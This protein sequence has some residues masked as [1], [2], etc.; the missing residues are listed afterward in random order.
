MPHLQ[1]IHNRFESQGLVVVAV[2]VDEE[3]EPARAFRAE[4]GFDFP[5]IFDA[6]RT[7]KSAM[8]GERGA[9]DLHH[10]PAGEPHT[11]QGPATGI[12]STLIDN[13][14]VWESDKIIELLTEV[15]GN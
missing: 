11:R 9:G 3:L 4:Y 2:A 1:K 13:P 15:V 5:M 10:R 14:M 7:V 12:S 8:G 6:N